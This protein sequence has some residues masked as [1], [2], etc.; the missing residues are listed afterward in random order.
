VAVA[1]AGPYTNLHLDP[2]TQPHHQ[3][4]HSVF[5]GQMPFLLPNQQ[6]QSTE[7]KDEGNRVFKKLFQ[8][9]PKAVSWNKWK[10]EINVT[11]GS[12]NHHYLHNGHQHGICKCYIKIIICVFAISLQCRN[13]SQTQ[14]PLSKLGLNEQQHAP[15]HVSY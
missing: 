9:F 10:T 8:L 6:R 12:L 3:P 11:I 13:Y 1:S 14:R 4:T 15:G 2:D 5:T 7:G